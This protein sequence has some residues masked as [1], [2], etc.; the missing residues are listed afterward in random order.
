MAFILVGVLTKL[1][2]CL[3]AYPCSNGKVGLGSSNGTITGVGDSRK[4]ILRW[5]DGGTDFSKTL[6]YFCHCSKV[7]AY[8]VAFSESHVLKFCKQVCLIHSTLLAWI[9]ISFFHTSA[10]VLLFFTWRKEV[11]SMVQ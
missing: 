1:R 2:A 11:I 3:G 8:V 4:F 7:S 10:V 5:K 9:E 6:L